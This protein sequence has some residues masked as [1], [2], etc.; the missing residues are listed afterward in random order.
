MRYRYLRFP[1][2]KPKAATFSYDDGVRQD[3]RLAEI[4]T[5]YGLKATFNLNNYHLRGEKGLTPEEVET[6]IL[7][8]GHEIAVHGFNHRAEGLLRPIEGIREVLDCRR[9]LEK[10]H[11]RI[12]RGMAYPDSG[13][14][15]FRNEAN[16]ENIK[17]YLQDLDVAYARSLG[18]DGGIDLP[19][20][21]HCWMPTA[22][23]SSPRIMEYLDMFLK[24]DPNTGYTKNRYPVLLYIWGH[25]YQF[26]DDNNWE[27][28]EDICQTLSQTQDVWFA[29]NMEIYDYVQAYYSLVYSADETLVYNPTLYT[30]WF[31]ADGIEYVVQPGQTLHIDER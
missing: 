8:P 22:A 1:G 10:T 2:G 12:V 16:Y 24:R 20:D 9:L 17:H 5:R 29:T 30:I 11:N 15:E 28:I 27:L 13:V 26:D 23:H 21:W 4:F 6:Y 3:I 25:S 14:R 31:Y 18:T 7:K 19:T